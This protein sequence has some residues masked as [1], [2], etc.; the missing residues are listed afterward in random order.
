MCEYFLP[1]FL[2][3]MPDVPS[4][5]W[6]T[7]R[8]PGYGI[9]S[10][11]SPP[12]NVPHDIRTSCFKDLTRSLAAIGQR[13]GHDLVESREFDLCFLVSAHAPS[14]LLL[15]SRRL[16]LSK[17]T[18]GPLTP[19]MVLYRMRGVTDIMRGSTSPS[20]AMAAVGGR[21]EGLS[22][23]LRAVAREVEESAERC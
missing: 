18:R 13:Q 19:P 23:S 6:T 17:M 22:W 1:T 9:S 7:A 20:L 8:L 15:I 10:V 2:T 14:Y 3:S 12:A 11:S 4:K 21:W 5:T 16:T